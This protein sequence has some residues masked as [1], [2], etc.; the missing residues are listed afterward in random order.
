MRVLVFSAS[1]PPA[2]RGGTVRAIEGL[3]AHLGRE[4]EF[5]VFARDREAGATKPLP[6]IQPGSWH[7]QGDAHVY[8]APPS[9]FAPHRMAAVAKEAGPHAYYVNSFFSP[10]FGTMPVLLRRIGAIPYRPIVLA[11]RAEL[12]PHSLR[13]KHEKKVAFLQV[14]RT[15]R[16]HRDVLWQA[17]TAEEAADIRRWFPD[18][19]VAVARD[20]SALTDSPSTPRPPKVRGQLRVIYLARITPLKNLAG[21]LRMVGRISGNVQMSVY[22][23]IE[24]VRYFR[25]CVREAKNL[26]GKVDVRFEGE[27]AHERVLE[28]LASHHVFLLPTSGE[29]FG[30]AILEA[31]LAGTIPIICDQT[32]WRDLA[33]TGAGWD[34]PL[35]DER[36]FVEALQRCVDMDD[37]EFSKARIAARELGRLAAQSRAVV[38]DNRALFAR[39][40]GRGPP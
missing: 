11:P 26:R 19:T 17:G 13:F 9:H 27:V 40:V 34:L 3:V 5:F 32:P 38:D 2:S 23:S 12:S 25:Q 10:T 4:I 20:L 18:G 37:E 16:L 36:A 14:V 33:R 21:A 35:D 39:A 30:H 1:Y 22:G 8:Y 28:T 7:R 24:D 29:S 15:L 31:L 6:G